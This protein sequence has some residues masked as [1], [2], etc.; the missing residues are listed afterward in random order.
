MGIV[1]GAL[2]TFDGGKRLAP[3]PVPDRDPLDEEPLISEPLP[4]AGNDGGVLWPSAVEEITTVG[5]VPNRPPPMSISG[6]RAANLA[7]DPL[8][9]TDT[10]WGAKLGEASEGPDVAL[11]AWWTTENVSAC[12]ALRGVV[13]KGEIE[14]ESTVEKGGG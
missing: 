10:R 11:A 4:L 13:F 5:S 1:N 3:T 8:E 12:S 14:G 2:G 6:G 9:G 7:L